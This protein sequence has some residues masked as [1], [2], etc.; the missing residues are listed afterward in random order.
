MG[1][2]TVSLLLYDGMEHRHNVHLYVNNQNEQ[3]RLHVG[4][5]ETFV[6]GGLGLFIKT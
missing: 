1:G 2:A 6:V 3:S 4:N 5:V